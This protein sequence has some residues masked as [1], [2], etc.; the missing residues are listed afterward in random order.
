MDAGVGE[1]AEDRLQVIR[2]GDGDGCGKGVGGGGV[3]GHDVDG[4]E[5]VDALSGRG[6]DEVVVLA[7]GL[8]RRAIAAG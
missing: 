5:V 8:K 4:L 1:A 3:G 6:V 7:R 2:S